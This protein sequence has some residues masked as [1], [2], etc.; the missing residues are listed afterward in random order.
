MSV[1]LK[2]IR[3][4]PPCSSTATGNGPAPGGSSSTAYCERVRP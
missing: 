1:R 3:Q 4:K 2:P